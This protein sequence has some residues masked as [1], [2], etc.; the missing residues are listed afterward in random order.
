MAQVGILSEQDRVELIDGE[1]L[2]MSPIG[3]R[4]S[5]VV[6]RATRLFVS[7]AG[8]RA[9]VRVQGPSGTYRDV[10]ELKATSSLAPS[11]PPECIVRVDDPIVP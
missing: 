1:V 9:I 11:L 7:L 4:H 3:P 2:A 10:D 6:D 8:E 5:A